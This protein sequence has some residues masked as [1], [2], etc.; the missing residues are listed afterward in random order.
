VPRL[1]L[2]GD[3]EALDVLAELSRHLEYFEVARLD[4]V[5]ERPLDADDHLV[6]GT[7][8]ADRGARLLESILRGGSPGFFALMP[9]A[10]TPAQRAILVAAQ[11]L[12]VAGL[13]Q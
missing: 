2:V 9:A 13:P 8:Q 4:D 3:D 10:R 12:G 7:L 1:F 6:V 11:L 5:P